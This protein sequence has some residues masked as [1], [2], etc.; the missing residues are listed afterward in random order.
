MKNL[1]KIVLILLIVFSGTSCG[2]DFFDINTN[3]NTSTQ[4][5]PGTLMA[6]A[7]LAISQVRLTTTNPDG[8]A[9]VQ[10]HKPVVVLTAP[11]TYG[12]SSIGNNNFYRFTFFGDIIKDLNLAALDAASRSESNAVAQLRILQAWSW[13]QGVDRWG[14][15]PFLEANNGETLFP[16]FDTEDVIYQGILDIL[17]NAI[18][19]VDMSLIGEPNTITNFD[20]V[21]AG[22]MTNWVKFANSLKL[23]CLMRLSYV[24]DRSS[25]IAALL[26]SGDFI[27]ALDGSEDAVFSYDASRA[28]QNFDYA[29]FDNFTNFGSFQLDE[30]GNRVHQRWRQASETMVDYLNDNNDPRLF[31]FFE[32]DISNTSG[33]I[34]GSPNGAAAQPPIE[35]R[36]YVSDYYIRQD[37]S[38]DW[39]L[40]SEYWLLAAEAYQRGLAPGGTTA[41]QTAF[42]NGINASMNVYDG[43]EFEIAA[44]DKTTFVSSLSL[45]AH[46]DPVAFIQEQQ[47]VALFYNGSEAWSNWR[48]TKQPELVPVVG[49]PISS[50]ISRIE[51]PE[52]A[53]LNPNAPDPAPLIQDPIYFERL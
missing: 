23:R 9:F 52:D 41:A 43:T 33:S 44:A 39:F 35:E 18:A 51:L 2:D 10:Q 1:K 25:E 38:D 13:I 29:T 53:F 36:G 49:A 12:F 24:E 3:P 40:A 15:I 30:D 7:L 50:I 42:E 27:S 31:S 5:P 48:R 16:Q 6:N 11:D 8:A 4:V 34:T 20:L 17:D 22:D 45:T 21:Y 19:T 26:S 14:S 32:P 28:N 46:A 47:W 37:K